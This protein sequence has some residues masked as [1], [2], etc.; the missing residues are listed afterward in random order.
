MDLKVFLNVPMYYCIHISNLLIKNIQ[1]L[2]S[3]I[4]GRKNQKSLMCIVSGV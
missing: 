3:L 4:H 2:I 1:H